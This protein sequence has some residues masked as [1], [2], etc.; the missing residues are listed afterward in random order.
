MGALC[1]EAYYELV[2]KPMGEKWCFGC[3]KRV[4]HFYV[5]MAPVDIYSYYGPTPPQFLCST[6]GKDR[7][8]FPGYEREWDDE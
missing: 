7:T 3:R 8:L 6:C 5:V 4:E 1:G 2:R